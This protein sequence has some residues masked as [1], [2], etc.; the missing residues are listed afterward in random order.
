LLNKEQKMNGASRNEADPSTSSGQQYSRVNKNYYLNK[1]NPMKY[2][3]SFVIAAVVISCGSNKSDPSPEN[4]PVPEQQPVGGGNS[5]PV[6]S[7]KNSSPYDTKK[8]GL[9]DTASESGQ[10]PGTVKGN[11]I[12]PVKKYGDN[13]SS[14]DDT[15]ME[16]IKPVHNPN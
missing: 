8:G 13:K 10:K 4:K 5:Q 16:R 12:P 14:L 3:I 6:D 15:A 2:F 9:N 7:G 1:K 11:N